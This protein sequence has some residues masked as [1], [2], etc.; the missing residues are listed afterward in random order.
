MKGACFQLIAVLC[1]LVNA[2]RIRAQTPA[3]STDGLRG[4]VQTVEFE[5]AGSILQAIA[6]QH[7]DS[8]VMVRLET[9]KKNDD[10]TTRYRAD[11][12][13][14]IAGEYDLRDFLERRDG[15]E[16]ALTPI[17]VVVMSQLDNDGGVDL[18]T[19]SASPPLSPSRYRLIA[20]VLGLAWLSWPVVYL[21]RRRSRNDE[22]I[23]PVISYRAPTLADQLRPLVEQAL[24]G[25]LST[26][27]QGRLELLMYAY[28]QK[29][30]HIDG[31]PAYAVSR[32]RRH[33]RSCELLQTVE[34]WL[35]AGPHRA[36]VT[37]DH[38]M[39]L[40]APY[41]RAPA[42]SEAAIANEGRQS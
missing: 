8:P 7:R 29:E 28:W 35:H 37:E 15:S 5:A 22:A 14:L 33:A 4:M 20:V 13:G 21:V 11:I 30:L 1:V 38:L 31:S 10:G 12:I 3:A 40:L 27:D 42:I 17:P 39:R 26:R 18:S 6:N 2:G 24:D 36:D 25:S 41:R 16:L 9:L 19:M 34:R 32:V 23:A